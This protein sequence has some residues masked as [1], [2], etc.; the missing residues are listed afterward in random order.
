MKVMKKKK[1]N[2]RTDIQSQTQRQ[3]VNL[4]DFINWINQDKLREDIFAGV[5]WNFYRSKK[6]WITSFK[7]WNALRTDRLELLDKW[8]NKNFKKS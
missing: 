1:K 4:D 2:S 3:E 8:L 7:K 6:D 5:D